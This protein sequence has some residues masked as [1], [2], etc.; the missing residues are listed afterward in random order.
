MFSNMNDCFPLFGGRRG[1][2]A[3]PPFRILDSAF[4]FPDVVTLHLKCSA[5]SE[6]CDSK[7]LEPGTSLYREELAA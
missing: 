3:L 5:V 1:V 4:S 7:G 2:G 6:P